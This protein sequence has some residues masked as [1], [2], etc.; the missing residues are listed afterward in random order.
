LKDEYIDGDGGQES[1]ALVSENPSKIRM[2]QDD[3]REKNQK[4]N[5]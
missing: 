3:K 4:K 1:I 5:E 2:E